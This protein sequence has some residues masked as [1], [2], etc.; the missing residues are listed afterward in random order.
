[1]SKTSG[2]FKTESLKQFNGLRMKVKNP[3]QFMNERR[4]QLNDL[5]ENV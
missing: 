4:E 1:M 2:L 5:I 3:E